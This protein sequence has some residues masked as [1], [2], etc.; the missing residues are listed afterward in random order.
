MPRKMKAEEKA[1]LY[2]ELAKLV[3]ADFHLDRAV[4]LLLGQDP[5]PPAAQFLQ[6]L[7]TGLAAGK[8]VSEAVSTDARASCGDLERALISAGEHSG[9]LG[10]AFRHLEKY[11][12]TVHSGVSQARSAL[13]YPLVLLH[14]GILLPELPK[15]IVDTGQSDNPWV[16]IGVSLMA[17]WALMGAGWWLWKT[18]T[19]KA[20]TSETAD[21]FLRTL[22]VIGAVRRHWSMARF[23]Q[24]F[25]AGLLAALRIAETMRLAGLASQSGVVREASESAATQVDEG[26]PVSVAMAGTGGRFPMAFVNSIATAEEAG[27]LDREM[28]RW[29]ALEMAEATGATQSAAEWLP[30]VAYGVIVVYVVWRIISMFLTQ[31]L[32]PYKALMQEIG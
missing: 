32:G 20:M 8:S 22:P 21:R 7:Q 26:L 6:N 29:A 25:H 17:V 28:E 19:H 13:I 18:L 4:S 16:N 14:V 31:Y 12:A 1:R 9:Q 2:R 15:I 5:A 3:G 11:F 27:T 10:Q 30:R 23:C 24:V